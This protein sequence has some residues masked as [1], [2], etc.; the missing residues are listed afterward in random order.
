MTCRLISLLAV[1]LVLGASA[2]GCHG[3]PEEARIIARE[4]RFDPSELTGSAGHPLTL[5]LANRGNE[6]HE[7]TS[8]LLRDPRVELI[9]APDDVLRR[10]SSSLRLPPGRSASV[11]LVAPPGTYTFSCRIRGHGAMQ[12]RI[13]LN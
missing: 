9:D 7:F 4:Y 1:V 6:A 12:G 13:T 5:V 10:A 3:E 8:L 2:P 11:T